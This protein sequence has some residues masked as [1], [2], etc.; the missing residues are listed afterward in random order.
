[1]AVLLDSY[2]ENNISDYKGMQGGTDEGVG[3]SFTGDGGILTTAKFFLSR[4]GSPTG[5]MTAKIYAH[6]GTYGTSSELTGS[7]LATSGTVDVTTIKGVELAE[8]L[9]RNGWTIYSSSP[10]T[11]K[12]YK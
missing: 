5:N 3:Q 1:M 2:S 9:K 12:F 6:T 4:V 10:W 8:R 7:A 11:I